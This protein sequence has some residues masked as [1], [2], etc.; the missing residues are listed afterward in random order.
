MQPAKLLNP[1][2]PHG[3]QMFLR[4]VAKNDYDLV[5]ILND[6]YVMPPIAK[7]LAQILHDKST[8][9]RKVPKIIY[10][11]P[12]DCHVPKVA[13]D[14]LR[15]V[16]VPVCY[17]HHGKAEALITL[18]ELESKLLEVPHGV[19]T[20]AFHPLPKEV[21]N[22]AK[23]Q[24][25]KADPDTFIVINVNRN[26]TR[27]QIQYSLLAF[28]EFKKRVPNS[29]MYIHTAV[30]DQGG[31]LMVAIGDLGLSP[32]DDIIFPV[33]YSPANPVPDETLNAIYN[34][35]D[36]FLT[37]H[38][39]EGWGLTVTEAMGAGTPVLV[40]CNTS[41]PQIVGENQERGWMY[42]CNDQA[43]IDNSGFRP[44][45]V[46]PD[47][48]DKMVEIYEDKNRDA[49]IAKA[50][51]WAVEHNWKTIG[52]R[53]VEIFDMASKKPAVQKIVGDMI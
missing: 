12:V 35:G 26:S 23:Q 10:Y 4:T 44:K 27:K 8:K 24:L 6:T 51:E 25:L 42:P 22:A 53:W 47:I 9:Q 41:M 19:D 11:F 18:P 50:R 3:M 29:K 34:M 14:F 36:L 45:G 30:Q 49:K 13:T 7:D 20:K 17:T 38:L 31:D 1:N 33:G 52:K 39:G 16:D 2:D 32:K 21:K 40:P 28:R 43:W 5:W 37:T 15:L 46:I 48:V